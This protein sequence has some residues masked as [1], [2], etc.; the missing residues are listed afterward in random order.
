MMSLQSARC[1]MGPGFPL[2]YSVHKHLKSHAGMCFTVHVSFA[3]PPA[4]RPMREWDTGKEAMQDDVP[5]ER[6]P[7]PG[8]P[9]V[10][11][12]AARPR[13]RSV[14]SGQHPSKPHMVASSLASAMSTL[15]V[16]LPAQESRHSAWC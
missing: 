8:R 13:E 4:P 3:E 12:Y 16:F 1:V 10:P 5:A 6:P 15:S 7:R 11:L 2:E 9:G 14:I